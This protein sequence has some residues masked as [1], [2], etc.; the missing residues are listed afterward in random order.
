MHD[1]KIVC[2]EC[3]YWE[4]SRGESAGQCRRYAP[5]PTLQYP[6]YP[7][8]G[9]WKTSPWAV[10]ENAGAIFPET[11]EADWCGEFASEL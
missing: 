6:V 9:D 1:P 5:R 8:K 10:G 3:R 7:P 4:H 2:K 11:I